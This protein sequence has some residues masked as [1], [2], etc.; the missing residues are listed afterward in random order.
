MTGPGGHR[1]STRDNCPCGRLS[2]GDSG[3]IDP[4]HSPVRVVVARKDAPAPFRGPA[5]AGPAHPTRAAPRPA[6]A[7][8]VGVHV[9]PTTGGTSVDTEG[10]GVAGVA[11]RSTVGTGSDTRR[12]GRFPASHH[13]KILVMSRQAPAGSRARGRPSKGK[14]WA[15]MTRLPVELEPMV[16]QRADADDLSYSEVIANAVATYFDQEPFATPRRP[17][18]QERLIA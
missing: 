5:D 12:M 9:P 8:R 14:R 1:P 4:A 3:P 11:H 17:D 16:R 2:D 15:V 7:T 18:A 10:V 6:G 13:G